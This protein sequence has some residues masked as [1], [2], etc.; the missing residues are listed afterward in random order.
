MNNQCD[1]QIFLSLLIIKS[2]EL[3]VDLAFNER[4]GCCKNNI[5]SSLDRIV[6]NQNYYIQNCASPK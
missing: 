4:G 1:N 6:Q 2:S 5:H 3:T